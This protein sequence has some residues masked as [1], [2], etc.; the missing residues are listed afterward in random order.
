MTTIDGLD[1]SLATAHAYV[2]RDLRHD[3]DEEFPILVG[4]TKPRIERML[5][6]TS[7]GHVRSLEEDVELLGLLAELKEDAQ[8]DSRG[9]CAQAHRA[10][11]EVI[12][13]R[14]PG[15]LSRPVEAAA[16]AQLAGAAPASG[17]PPVADPNVSQVDRN[18]VLVVGAGKMGK[19]ITYAL[20]SAGYTVRLYDANPDGSFIAQAV[21]TVCGLIAK[22]QK[23]NL[24]TEEQARDMK[25]RLTASNA[26]EHLPDLVKDAGAVMEAIFENFEAKRDLFQALNEAAAPETVFLTNTSM[27]SVN[28]LAEASGRPDRFAGAHWFWPAYVNPALEITYST[29]MTAAAREAALQ[30]GQKARKNILETPDVVGFVVDRLFVPWLNEGILITDRLQ[31]AHP[32]VNL[33]DLMVLVDDVARKYFGINLGPYELMNLTGPAITFHAANTLSKLGDYYKPAARLAALIKEADAASTKPQWAIPSSDNP[34]KGMR[35]KETKAKQ[36]KVLERLQTSFAGVEYETTRRLIGERLMGVM[37]RMAGQ[38][39]EE[40]VTPDTIDRALRVALDWPDG[41]FALMGRMGPAEAKRLADAI[42]EKSFLP[43]RF[44]E[45]DPAVL[46]GLQTSLVSISVDEKTGIAR[47]TV[48]RPAKMNVL[49]PELIRD[50]S[51]RFAEAE[52]DSRVRTIVLE[53]AKGALAGADIKF[54]TDNLKR[55]RTGLDEILQFVREGLELFNRI[56]HSPKKVIAV[57]DGPTFGGGLELALA[58][59]VI[60]ATPRTKLAFPETKL[61]IIPGLMGGKRLAQR[62]GRDSSFYLQVT[63]DAQKPMD[64]QTAYDLGIADFLAGPSDIETLIAGIASE[65]LKLREGILRSELRTEMND[66]GDAL[67]FLLSGASTPDRMPHTQAFLAV[68]KAAQ[69]RPLAVLQLARQTIEFGSHDDMLNL[70]ERLFLTPMAMQGLGTM[71]QKIEVTNR[72]LEQWN[73]LLLATLSGIEAIE[74]FGTTLR[75]R[76]TGDYTAA[77][78]KAIVVRNRINARSGDGQVN[79]ISTVRIVYKEGEQDK[80][81]V[82]ERESPGGVFAIVRSSPDE[83]SPS[84]APAVPAA[85]PAAAPASPAPAP[86]QGA[87]STLGIAPTLIKSAAVLARPDA[88]LLEDLSDAALVSGPAR[89]EVPL[90]HRGG[91]FGARAGSVWRQGPRSLVNPLGNRA[92]VVRMVRL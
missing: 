9:A 21:A 25:L 13:A 4:E 27:L 5:L 74:K 70:L 65:E 84:A 69:E 47:L 30:F 24:I 40:G 22:A 43:T 48:E 19:D 68:Q 29:Q 59:D 46:Q 3:E 92:Q 89:D 18:V 1:D 10:L 26:P 67:W 62:V 52:G 41:P 78:V 57:L 87:R 37:A 77:E 58:A 45:Q 75:F 15:N 83:A 44:F 38:L 91:L 81:I 82:I 80:V 73:E 12:Q 63:G 36:R 20:L 72:T 8:I 35:F 2:T 49:T 23:N 90:H 76:V 53:G 11:E 86:A 66:A 64:G 39:T 33:E 6:L 60:V 88:I 31:E 61:G 55:G 79:D 54:F 51:A 17:V 28:K 32:D 50:L 14:S 85:S 7:P 56:D 34:D 71:G 16:A 42:D